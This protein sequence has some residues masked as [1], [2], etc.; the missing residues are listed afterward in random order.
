MDR[1]K[2]KLESMCEA[3]RG[4]KVDIITHSMGGLLVKC[5][6]ALHPQVHCDQMIR[7]AYTSL[8]VG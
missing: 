6:L 2:L 1:M 8:E 5:F 4:R 3:S 7:P